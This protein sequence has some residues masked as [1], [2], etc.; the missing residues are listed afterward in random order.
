M[1]RWGLDFAFRELRPRAPASPPPPR[2]YTSQIFRLSESPT[3]L[4]L[5]DGFLA[6]FGP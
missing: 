5:E 3:W 6:I 1:G 4:A 2:R